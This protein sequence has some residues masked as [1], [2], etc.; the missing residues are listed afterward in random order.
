MHDRPDLR[1]FQNLAGLPDVRAVLDKLL[2]A[3]PPILG[4]QFIG[5]YLYGSLALG[6]FNPN[7]SDIDFLVVTAGELSDEMVSDLAAM[8]ARIAASDSRWALELEGAYIPLPALRRYDPAQARH[9]HIDRGNGEQLRMEQHDSDW[10]IQRHVLREHGVTLAGPPISTLIDPVSPDD[11]RQATLDV[12]HNWWQPMLTNPSYLDSGGY[13][14]YAVLTMCRILYTLRF[15]GV[16]SKL[17]AAQWGKEALD[18]RFTS[19]I[20]QADVWQNGRP[21]DKLDETRGFIHYTLTQ[22]KKYEPPNSI[23]IS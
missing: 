11:L 14:V 7:R 22:S 23:G 2:T 16:V 15:G 6:D 17:A 19:L 20:E 8:H 9:P 4:P 3:V 10:V 1:G 21:F 12:L 5:L 13:R 18:C